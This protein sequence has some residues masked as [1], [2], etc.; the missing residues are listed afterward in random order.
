M[1]LPV[2]SGVSVSLGRPVIMRQGDVAALPDSQGRAVRRR[3]L[4]A[5]AYLVT[6]EH[7]VSY[8]VV[9]GHMGQTASPDA[10]ASMVV[11]V[12]L[13]LG[14]AIVHLALLELTAAQVVPLGTM[15]RTVLSCAP[16]GKEASVT[17]P[18]GGVSVFL[19]GWDSP[20]NKH[21]LGGAMA[22]SAEVHATVRM[23]L[24]V[25]Q[26]VEHAGV[27]WAGLGP[28][29][30]QA[31]MDHSAKDDV[32]LA[33]LDWTV[34]SHV[35]VLLKLHVILQQDGASAS[36]EGQERDVKKTVVGTVLALTA[37]CRASVPTGPTV[38]DSL[39]DVYARS[40]C[41]APPVLK[42]YSSKPQDR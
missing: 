9:Q 25:T 14:F 42:H 27:D 10:P 28:D 12:T 20:A 29:V 22:C 6:T 15:G 23:V 32:K 39:V 21:V 5:S 37:P 13:G 18:V 38:T 7:A 19:V 8:D 2:Q 26:S 17:Q 3:V 35:T 16:V 1:V 24:C 33:S 40:P 4:L 34:E 31:T 36:Q 30:T 41:W 11:A